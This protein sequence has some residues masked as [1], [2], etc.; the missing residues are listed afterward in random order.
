MAT[1]M[2]QEFC[3][4]NEINLMTFHGSRKVEHQTAESE[5]WRTYFVWDEHG[6]CVKNSRPYVQTPL[7]KGKGQKVQMDRDVSSSKPNVPEFWDGEVKPG[8]VFLR[9]CI[10]GAPGVVARRSHSQVQRAG[11][12][13]I[14]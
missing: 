3:A 7:Y 5:Q 12:Q 6:Y 14:Q 10:T 8:I 2:R 13:S 4:E 9:R 1:E 11:V